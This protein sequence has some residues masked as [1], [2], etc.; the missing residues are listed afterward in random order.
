MDLDDG[1]TAG[2]LRLNQQRLEQAIR[3]VPGWEDFNGTPESATGVA[4][5]MIDGTRRISRS[6]LWL[7]DCPSMQWLLLVVRAPSEAEAVR[8]G[9]EAASKYA[10]STP[11]VEVEYLD[12]NGTT[13]VLIEDAG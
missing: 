4:A 8:I 13:G 10:D 6:A 1:T 9:A 7:V 2:R 12:P 11:I 5:E 3:T